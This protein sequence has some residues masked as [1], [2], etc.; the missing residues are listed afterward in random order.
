MTQFADVVID[1]HFVR[2]GGKSYAINKINSV[3]IRGLTKKGSSAYPLLWV[4]AAVLLFAAIA[5]EAKG[6]SIFLAIIAALFGLRSWSKRHSVTTYS[7]FLVTSSGEAQAF[8]SQNGSEIN[9][10]R[11][12][13]ESAI[14]K[15]A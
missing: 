12:R 3:E 5:G 9:L 15:A 8:A 13:I 1:D 10:M 14:A 11:Q 7:L 4:L 2:V 6:V